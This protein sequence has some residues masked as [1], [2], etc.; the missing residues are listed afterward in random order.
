MARYTASVAAKAGTNTANT[1]LLNLV[2]GGTTERVQILEIYLVNTAAITTAPN[3]AVG[4]STARGT[5]SATAT[6]IRQDESQAGAASALDTAWTVNPTFTTTDVNRIRRELLSTAIGQEFF[7]RPPGGGLLVPATA[8]A[9][10][11]LW[12]V[13]ASGNPNLGS[14][15]GHV[16]WEED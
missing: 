16:V 11:V 4:R 7:W 3:L 13:N 9:G 14:F 2:G 12:N 5:Q 6:V 1:P 10:V 15:F 8:G